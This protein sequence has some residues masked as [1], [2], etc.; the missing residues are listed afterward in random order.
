ME[1]REVTDY[2]SKIK[3][4]GSFLADDSIDIVRQ[5]IAKSI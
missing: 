3:Y 4:K 1:V 2:T 5:Q